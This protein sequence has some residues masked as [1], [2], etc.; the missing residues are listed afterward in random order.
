MHLLSRSFINNSTNASF[1][2]CM[3][4]SLV[5]VLFDVN[6]TDDVTH[7]K[8]FRAPHKKGPEYGIRRACI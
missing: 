5:S 4:V 3:D 6:F 1:Y 8:S 2:G 7:T